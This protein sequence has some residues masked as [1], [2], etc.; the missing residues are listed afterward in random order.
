MPITGLWADGATMRPAR[1]PMWT[2]LAIGSL[3]CCWAVLRNVGNERERAIRAVEARIKAEREAA[4]AL[5]REQAAA[6]ATA[7]LAA[8]NAQSKAAAKP[9]KVAGRH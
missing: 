2:I 7:V 4:E 3:F 6:K 5:A 9:A 1:P 8:A